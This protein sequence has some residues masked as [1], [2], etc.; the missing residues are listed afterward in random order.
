MKRGLFLLHEGLPSTVV[1]SQIVWNA[2]ALRENGVAV[3]IWSFAPS[4]AAWRN[5]RTML[6]RLARHEVPIR[7]F[8]GFPNAWPL[9]EF[10]NAALLWVYLRRHRPDFVHARTEYSAAVA[11][12]IKATLSYRLVWDARGDTLSEY[13]LAVQGASPLRRSM[14]PS[15]IRRIQSRLDRAARHADHAIFVS[16]ALRRVQGQDIAAEKTSILPCFADSQLFFYDPKLRNE[17]RSRLGFADDELIILYSGSAAAWQCV[18]ETI[19]LMAASI[20]ANPRCRGLIV[21]GEKAAFEAII[22]T[23]SRAHFVLASASLPEMNGY[24]NAADVGVM[25]RKESPVNWVASPVKFSEYGLTGLQIV[26]GSAVEQS[27]AF[28][29]QIGNLIE[30]RDIERLVPASPGT[31]PA[32]ERRARR[33]R[34]L[35]SRQLLEQRILAIYR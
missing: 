15:K 26:T 29:T 30:P 9:S 11:S 35:C 6:P 33:A 32:R 20:S 16:E 8:L 24:L 31:D 10:V 23:E 28:G 19:A 34:E 1:E 3:E 7:L 25:L 18:P 14:V 5:A 12:M 27:H 22:P 21:T 2:R 17:V 13:E 4:L